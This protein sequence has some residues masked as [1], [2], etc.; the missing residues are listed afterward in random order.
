MK[1]FSVSILMTNYNKSVFLNKS[2]NSC[3]KQNYKKKEIFIF[4]DCSTDDSKKILKNLKVENISIIYN[5]KKKFKSGALNQLYGTKKIFSLSKGEIIFLL[6]S[7]D[8]LKKN[9]VIFLEKIFRDNKNLNFIQDI[10]YLSKKRGAFKLNKKNTSYSVWPSFYPTSCITIRRKFF[11]DFLKLSCASKYSH[12]E[13]DARLCIYAFLKK[14]FKTINKILTIYNFDQFGIT[15]K[16]KKFGLN[17]WK[18]R[19]EAYSY[20]KYLMKKMKIKFIP[21]YDYYFT[22]LI[23]Y[24]I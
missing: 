13:I 10:P 21:G 22:K 16:Y 7:D 11:L 4:D 19:N 8:Y 24:I 9:K 17:W 6:D 2:I 23:N 18:K 3:I 20:M 15:S 5:K 14:E 12:L 1:N